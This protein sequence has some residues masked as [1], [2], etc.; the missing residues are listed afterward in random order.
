MDVAFF[1]HDLQHLFQ[2]R[3]PVSVVL[4]VHLL[5]GGYASTMDVAL[6]HHNLYHRLQ[7]RQGQRGFPCPHTDLIQR[8]GKLFSVSDSIRHHD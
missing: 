6:F 8:N 7:A 1:R 4:Y 5:G 2:A 3:G